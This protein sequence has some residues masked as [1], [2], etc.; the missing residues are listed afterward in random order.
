MKITICS[1][2]SF[3]KEI[4][5]TKKILEGMGHK[6]D[7]PNNA[8]L[9]ANDKLSAESRVESIANKRTDD[10]IKGHYDKINASDAILVLNQEKKG[11]KNY[12]GG[13]TFLEIG[14]AH[15]LS[16]KNIFT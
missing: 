5:D 15:I 8:E 6:V 7:I 13:N 12:I 11:I 9:Y 2:M 1:S 3:A 4:M 14:F 16:K 10:L